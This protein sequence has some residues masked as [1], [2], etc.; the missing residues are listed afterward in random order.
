MRSVFF[1]F[2]GGEV[3]GNVSAHLRSFRFSCTAGDKLMHFVRENVKFT[4][5]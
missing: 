3:E 4:L 2:L 1:L 5:R